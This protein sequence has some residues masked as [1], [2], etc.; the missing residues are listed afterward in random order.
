MNGG[1]ITVTIFEEAGP[2]AYEPLAS[3]TQHLATS[4]GCELRL[5]VAGR[6]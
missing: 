2:V 6:V 3:E 4:L 5:S 1:T